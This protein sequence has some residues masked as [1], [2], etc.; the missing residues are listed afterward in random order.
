[1]RACSR[2]KLLVVII[3]T[4][5]ARSRLATTMDRAILDILNVWVSLG[6]IV[7]FFLFIRIM[8]Q[9]LR[10]EVGFVVEHF[11]SS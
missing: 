1:M 2:L 11:A 8:Q 9:Q 4:R 5:V 7:C 3:S 10:K 6:T